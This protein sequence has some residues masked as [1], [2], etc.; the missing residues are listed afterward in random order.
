MT[1]R[2]PRHFPHCRRASRRDKPVLFPER[3]PDTAPE[4]SKPAQPEKATTQLITAYYAQ[5]PRFWHRP[6]RQTK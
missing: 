3:R 1:N 2:S 4:Q 5:H 6:P